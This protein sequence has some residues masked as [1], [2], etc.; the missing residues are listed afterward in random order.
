MKSKH[1]LYFSFLILLLSCARPEALVFED[2][3]ESQEEIKICMIGDMGMGNKFQQEMAYALENEAC[4]RIYF[5][6]DLVYPK[7]IKS[8]DDPELEEKFLSY[9][10]SLFE[11]NPDLKINLLLGN[12]DHAGDPSAWKDVDKKYKGYFF[13]NYFYMVDYGGL[14][15]VALDS[16][17]YYYGDKVAETGK[18]TLWLSRMQSRLKKCKVKVAVTHHPFKGGGL[19]AGE[20]DWEGASG[21]LKAFLDTYVI[22]NFDIHVAGHV[23][24]VADDGKDEG[25][26]MLVSGAGAEAQGP[27]LPGYVVLKWNPSNPKSIGYRIEHVNLEIVDAGETPQEQQDHHEMHAYEKLIP[28]TRVE[29]TWYTK[30]WDMIK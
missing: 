10:S 3:I 7:G 25:T 23:H 2:K 4:D 17:F 14:C 12:H 16:S 27:T 19:T 15:I 13:P 29:E 24:T 26:R 1:Y 28:K 6:G 11:K 20:D 21:A 18:Q 22:G 30:I 8:V 9:Y 5:L